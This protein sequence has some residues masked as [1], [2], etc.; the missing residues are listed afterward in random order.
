[1]RV[2]AAVQKTVGEVKGFVDNAPFVLVCGS[3][4]EQAFVPM[5]KPILKRLD[6]SNTIHSRYLSRHPYTISKKRKSL[7]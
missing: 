2:R 5:N 4:K 1:M 7:Q 3:L 6:P